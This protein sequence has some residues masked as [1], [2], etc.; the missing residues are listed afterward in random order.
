MLL[1]QAPQLGI[2]CSP[3]VRSVSSGSQP[4]LVKS[5]SMPS[6]S[7][8]ASASCSTCVSACSVRRVARLSA[9]SALPEG[10]RPEQVAYR[11]PRDAAKRSVAA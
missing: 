9:P 7:T 4:G 6:S 1:R 11:T 8:T 3:S 5:S 2:R 10:I